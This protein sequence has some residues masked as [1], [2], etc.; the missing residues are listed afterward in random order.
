MQYK[1]IVAFGDSFTRGDE[2]A[3][4]PPQDSKDGFAHSK[5]TWP[6]LLAD[7]LG[8]EYVCRANGGRGNSWISNLVNRCVTRNKQDLFIV[9]WTYFG[10]FDF[11]DQEDCWSTMCPG[12]ANTE[13]GSQYYRN[14][15]NDVWNLLRNLQIIY[16]TLSLLIHY[17]I[18]YIFTCHDETFKKSFNDLRSYRSATQEHWQD[19]ILALS[20]LVIPSI[21]EFENQTFKAWAV[22]NN[23]EIGAGGHPLEKAHLEAANYINMVVTEGRAN[24]H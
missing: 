4:C 18:D 14:F 12:S 20:R 24:G 11:L 5:H 21:T 8:A 17:K 13:L 3:D 16:S 1:K 23:F 19:S 2:L 10:R 9:N 15:D 7:K 6:A 22:K